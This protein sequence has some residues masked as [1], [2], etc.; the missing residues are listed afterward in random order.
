MAT[1]PVRTDEDKLEEVVS[2]LTALVN[3]FGL[4]PSPGERETGDI[5]KAVM[6]ARTLRYRW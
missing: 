4:D 6:L 2:I 1:H 5:N 3:D